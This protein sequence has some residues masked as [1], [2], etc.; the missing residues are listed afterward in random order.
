MEQTEQTDVKE[1]A[2][3][4]PTP[5][6]EQALEAASADWL[7]PLEPYGPRKALEELTRRLMLMDT[8]KN[9]LNVNEAMLVIQTAS[10]T[11]LNPFA[12]E[13]WAWVQILRSGKRVL[14]IMPGR[15][16][17]L[18][19]AREQAEH[20]GTHFNEEYRRI[21]DPE[22]RAELAIPAGA[23]AFECKVY[24]SLTR[25][26]W[27]KSFT[28]LNHAGMKADQVL[29]Q[30]GDCPYA[31]GYGYVTADEMKTLD[32][33][34]NKMAH[35][36]RASKR[37]FMS[38]LKKKF[39]L[40]FGAISGGQAGMTFDD[41]VK[42]P[43][44][45]DEI[46]EGDKGEVVEAG[47]GEVVEAGFET[48]ETEEPQEFQNFTKAEMELRRKPKYWREGIAEAV[49]EAG[50]AKDI[51][52]AAA[53]LAMTPFNKAI[54]EKEAVGWAKEYRAVKK[55][56]EDGDLNIKDFPTNRAVANQATM[57]YFAN[58]K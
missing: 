32:D 17:L 33:G 11:Q 39:D 21:T 19:L 23:L 50:F 22:E 53:V 34:S 45:K 58:M 12:Q 24:D 27:V 44:R 29:A 28:D 36:E 57:Q 51:F 42:P 55:A 7:H 4:D 49:I 25:E 52:N 10:T 3:A 5:K 13:L 18:R 9:P 43:S 30:I 48:I 40:P 8:S 26:S 6:E 41:Y 20:M 35:A 38:G 15:R 56:V 47:E 54:K 2:T 31:R 14:T 1:E 37:A 46:V 16:G